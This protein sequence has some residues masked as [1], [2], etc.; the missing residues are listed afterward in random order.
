MN[1][2]SDQFDEAATTLMRAVEAAGWRSV[3][4]LHDRSGHLAMYSDIPPAAVAVVL[5]EA[6]EN[7]P[8]AEG[9]TIK[10]ERTT[11]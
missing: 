8:T 5:R 7:A 9:E 3:I 2:I 11:Q 4:L 10:L 1:S 6:L